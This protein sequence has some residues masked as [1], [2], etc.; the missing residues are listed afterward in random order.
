MKN[1]IHIVL[2]AGFFAS[3]M[4]HVLFFLGRTAAPERTS[5]C[6]MSFFLRCPRFLSPVVAVPAGICPLDPLALPLRP[7]PCGPDWGSLLIGARGRRLGRFGRCSHSMLVHCPG[8][9]VRLGVAGPWREAL[10]KAG[11]GGAGRPAGGLCGTEIRGRP[12][13]VFTAVRTYGSVRPGHSSGGGMAAAPEKRAWKADRWFTEK[14]RLPPGNDR[15][16]T[17]DR[18]RSGVIR[19]NDQNTR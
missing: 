6:L 5:G 7:V 9:R 16:V 4:L 18:E 13:S 12:P 14:H 10:P 15:S 11:H 19:Q 8:S 17:K 1:R 2:L 3:L